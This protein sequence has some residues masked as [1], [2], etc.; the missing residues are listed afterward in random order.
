MASA[1]DKVIVRS[2]EEA[3]QIHDSETASWKEARAALKYLLDNCPDESAMER[4]TIL[5]HEHQW[6]T[7]EV[8]RWKKVYKLSLK[9]ARYA[10]ATGV[11]AGLCVGV[12]F[13]YTIS[14]AAFVR[15]CEKDGYYQTGSVFIHKT[16]I[17]CPG[18]PFSKK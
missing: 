6:I 16:T 2:R 1:N 8:E 17:E 11:A 7:E 4:L 13:A 9:A 12:Y 14:E 5:S 18:V 15:S 3:M 10:V